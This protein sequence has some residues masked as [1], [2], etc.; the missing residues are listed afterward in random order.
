MT[1]YSLN[2]GLFIFDKDSQAIVDPIT[3]LDLVA[4]AGFTETELLAEGEEW[5]TPSVH[6]T[7]N[8]GRALDR[9]GIYPTPYI[10]LIWM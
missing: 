7:S 2:S 5:Q 9:L 4:R 10:H 1:T 3:A 8:I 6:D